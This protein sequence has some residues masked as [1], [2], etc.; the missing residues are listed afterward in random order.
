VKLNSADFQKGGFSF[1]DSLQV[2]E[3]LDAAGV[4]LIEISGGNYEQPTMFGIEGR[5]EDAA[6]TRRDSTKRREAFFLEYAARMRERVKTP[7]AVTGGFRTRQAME[8]ALAQGEVNVVGLA[9]PL[10]TEPDL[11]RRLIDGGAEEA[12]RW[13]EK[14]GIGKGRFGPDSSIF[15]FKALNAFSAIAWYYRQLVALADGK[16]LRLDLH[17]LRALFEHQRSEIGIARARRKTHR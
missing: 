4:D 7:L 3:W 6:D 14:I 5:P 11:P 13:E 10:C 8:D 1:E 16:P 15:L 9:R 17:P 2:A 12:V